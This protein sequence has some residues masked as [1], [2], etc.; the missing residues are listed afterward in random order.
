MSL[1][2]L[3]NKQINDVT[4]LFLKNFDKIKSEQKQKRSVTDV[5]GPCVDESITTNNTVDIDLRDNNQSIVRSDPIALDVTNIIS[6][7]IVENGQCRQPWLIFGG[8]TFL[9]EYIAASPKPI[10]DKNDQVT[11]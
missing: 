9:T 8:C 6:Q 11:K 2:F 10:L 5:D 3:D 7:A 4:R 1:E